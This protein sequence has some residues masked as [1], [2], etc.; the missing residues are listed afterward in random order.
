V[1]RPPDAKRLSLA[2]IREA[3]HRIRLMVNR[4][5]VL[6]GAILD[7]FSGA[8]LFFKCENLQKA[9]AFRARGA[10]N[11]FFF[12]TDA[13]ASRGAVARSSGDR[14]AAL[15]CAAALRGVPAFLV[16]PE[17]APKTK[18]RGRAAL[19][20]PDYFVPVHSGSETDCS[21]AGNRGSWRRPVGV[22][23][24]MLPILR[25]YVVVIRRWAGRFPWP[26]IYSSGPRSG[27]PRRRPF[28]RL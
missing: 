25:R 11:A 27:P 8:R 4:T 6:T 1:S 17:T 2:M 24:S 10:T 18:T 22:T 19:W 7:S 9:G 23:P 5:P 20:R 21:S 3:N 12:L 15:A 26:S 14:A 13:E 16:V 28:A